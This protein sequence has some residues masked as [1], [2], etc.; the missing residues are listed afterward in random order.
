MN[1]FPS[2][3]D[4]YVVACRCVFSSLLVLVNCEAGRAQ[5]PYRGLPDLE[6]TVQIDESTWDR[7]QNIFRKH[8]GL[9]A[10]PFCVQNVGATRSGAATLEVFHGRRKSGFSLSDPRTIPPLEENQKHCVTL[11]GIPV[12]TEWVGNKEDFIGI[13]DPE[14]PKFDANHKNNERPFSLLFPEYRPD[15][16]DLELRIAGRHLAD[17][18]GSLIVTFMVANLGARAAP[19]TRVEIH[20]RYGE[21]LSQPHDID[22]LDASRGFQGEIQIPVESN[23]IGTTEEFFGVVD[24]GENIGDTKRANNIDNFSFNFEEPASFGGG[25]ATGTAV[26]AAAATLFGLVIWGIRRRKTN[27]LPA[28]HA[29]VRGRARHDAGTQSIRPGSEDVIL[30]SLRIRPVLDAGAQWIAF[31][32]EATKG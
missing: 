32:S 27:A 2:R 5:Q 29:A 1:C 16:P 6:L 11:S 13:V 23:W 14:Q 20:G 9:L 17:Q 22:V 3:L 7:R 21:L 19:P 18:S 28:V 15:M 8:H 31:D 10:I 4:L 24:P 25:F 30:P 12:P 26:T